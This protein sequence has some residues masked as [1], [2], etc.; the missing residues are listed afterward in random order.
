MEVLS[1]YRSLSKEQQGELL[2]AISEKIRSMIGVHGDIEVLVEYISVML[3]SDKHRDLIEN[4]LE[5]FLQD[6]SKHFV[7]WLAE[8]LEAVGGKKAA[9]ATEGGSSPSSPR[10]KTMQAPRENKSRSPARKK[11]NGGEGAPPRR[12]P[13][14]LGASIFGR[15]LRAAQKSVKE[16]GEKAAV[17][18]RSAPDRQAEVHRQESPERVERPKL[19]P[20]SPPRDASESYSRSCSRGRGPSPQ[21]RAELQASPRVRGRAGTLAAAVANAAASTAGTAPGSRSLPPRPRRAPPLPPPPRAVPMHMVPGAPPNTASHPEDARFAHDGRWGPPALPHGGAPYPGVLAPGPPPSHHPPPRAAQ[22]ASKR[23]RLAPVVKVEEEED[24]SRWHFHAPPGGQS[25]PRGPA[26]AAFSAGPLPHQMVAA[27]PGYPAW[28]ATVPGPLPTATAASAV[29]NAHAVPPPVVQ[30]VFE[31]QQ[32]PT[33]VQSSAPKTK[34]RTVSAP[35]RPKNFVPQKWRVVVAELVVGASE[36][37]D[38]KEVRVLHDG[39][40]VESVGPPF[41]LPNGVVRVEIAHPSSAA[42]P[43]PIGWVTQDIDGVKT[44]QPGPQ[45]LQANMRSTP[46]PQS[47]GGGAGW[48]PQSSYRPKGKGGGKGTFTNVSWRP[49]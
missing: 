14:G 41:T 40:I 42:Y 34:T 29:V 47:F 4:E 8:K 11:T 7:A 19:R 36:H 27:A 21:A 15:A 30:T 44:L 10:R 18:E 12:R 38:S 32:P 24:T 37:I 23:A 22:P 46:R 3:Q 28:P 43:N 6:K 9:K 49:S 26:P 1:T 45:P 13:G 48:R 39:E 2:G 25:P 33:P 16:T 20:R 17:P 5:A 35:P 31:Y